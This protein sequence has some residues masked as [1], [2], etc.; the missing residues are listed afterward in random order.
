MRALAGLDEREAAGRRG[1][2]RKARRA[3][4]DAPVAVSTQ[5]ASGW[6]NWS[7]SAS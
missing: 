2:E 3:P 7:V 1:S 5:S 4:S 6:A